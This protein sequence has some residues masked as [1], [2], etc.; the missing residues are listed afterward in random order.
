M[1]RTQIVPI[2]FRIVKKERDKMKGRERKREKRNRRNRR[3]RRNMSVHR[4]CQPRSLRFA[5]SKSINVEHLVPGQRTSNPANT[6]GKAA[7]GNCRKTPRYD[8][9]SHKEKKTDELE[10][11]I[12]DS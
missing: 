9:F 7:G 5:L 3:N 1:K 6:P 10:D 2:R 8:V 12:W 11:W 4:N